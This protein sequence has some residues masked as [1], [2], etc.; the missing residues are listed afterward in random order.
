M[1]K[2]FLLAGFGLLL[3]TVSCSDQGRDVISGAGTIIYSSLEGGCWGIDLDNGIQYEFRNLPDIFKN[4]GLRVRIAAQLSRGQAS[5][6]Y[7][8]SAIID[9]ID[10]RK[11]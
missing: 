9:I 3:L 6:C 1:S 11:L 4:E 10:I 7:F 8:S 5:Y 2:F